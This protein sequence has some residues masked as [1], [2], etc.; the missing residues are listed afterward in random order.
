MSNLKSKL[1]AKTMGC[2]MQA[3]DEYSKNEKRSREF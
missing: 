2:L 1:V 3:E